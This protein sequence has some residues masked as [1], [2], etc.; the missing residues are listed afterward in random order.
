MFHHREIEGAEKARDLYEKIGRPS[1]KYF[2]H[3]LVNH[4]VR[5]CSVTVDDIKRALITYGPDPAEVFKGKMTKH[6]SEP[7]PS[8]TAI[9]IPSYIAKHHSN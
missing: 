4:L 7:I 9:P 5:N 8:Y 1:E 3:V 6:R 2:Q